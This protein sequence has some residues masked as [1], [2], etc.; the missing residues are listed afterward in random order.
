[1]FDISGKWRLCIFLPPNAAHMCMIALY[2][3]GGHIGEFDASDNLIFIFFYCYAL[4]SLSKLWLAIGDPKP[5]C[6]EWVCR[7]QRTF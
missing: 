5:S 2:T 3:G 1:M 4:I 6:S 7:A